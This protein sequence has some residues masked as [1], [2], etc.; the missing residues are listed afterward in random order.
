MSSRILIDAA[1][2]SQELRVAATNNGVVTH[3]DI[4]A[5]SRQQTKA[6]IYKGK[7]TRV[8][9]SLEAC[10]VDYGQE[11]HGFLPLKDISPQYFSKEVG[12]NERPSI[13]DV[14]KEGQELIIQVEKIERGNKGAALTTYITLA[15]SYLVLMPNSPKAGGVSRR[16]EGDER[17]ELLDILRQLKTPEQMG[18][19]IRTASIGKTLEDLQWDLDILIKLWGSINTV[20]NDNAA[21]LLIHQESNAMIRALRDYIRQETSEIVINNEDVYNEAR[22]YMGLI[23]P[24][25]ADKVTL[26][27]DDKPLF[28]H[29]QIERQIEAIFSHEVRLPSGGSLAIDQTEALIAIDINSSKATKGSDI[30]ETAFATN[31]EA[32]DEIARQ[33]RLRDIGGLIVIDFIDMM[34]NQNQRAVED[35]IRD[36]LKGDRAKVQI[37]RIS[38][39][40]LLEMSRQR[41]RA[42]MAESTR[43]ACPHCEGHGMVRSIPS[44]ALS[45]LRDIEEKAMPSDVSQIRVHLPLEVATYLLNE[46]REGLG[47]IEKRCTISLL[48]IPHDNMSLLEKEIEIIRARGRHTKTPSF[49]LAVEFKKASDT[50]VENFGISDTDSINHAPA[51]KSLDIPDKPT[52]QKKQ[53]TTKKT[54]LLSKII[55]A[56]FG[57][58]KKKTKASQQRRRPQQGRGRQ[59]NSR[60][61]NQGGNQQRRSSQS[62]NRRNTTRNTSS[63]TRKPQNRDASSSNT[64]SSNSRDS[65]RENSSRE[66]SSRENSSRDSGSRD[67]GSRSNNR[68]NNRNSNNRRNS[69]RTRSNDDRRGNEKNPSTAAS[70]NAP[71]GNKAADTQTKTQTPRQESKPQVVKQATVQASVVEKPKAPAPIAAAAP[72][73]QFKPRGGMPVK[74]QD[75][76]NKED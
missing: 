60:S 48:L 29:Y 69:N 49:K 56:L 70:S 52:A 36:A 38:R 50:D 42:T 54:G 16:I 4:E 39:F 43:I 18:I 8:E 27:T 28:T 75:Q 59:Q 22:K 47:Q 24:D 68:S 26:Y 14:I 33:L 1:Y 41:L 72:R 19:I 10:F 62:S 32:A 11:R 13:K 15:G 67:S 51:I 73:T 40:G 45:I 6:F 63:N 23:R 46:Q 74:K 65:S 71:L 12:E 37:G 34:Q 64:S 35:R 58:P 21:P 7:V 25:F 55:S 76:A 5:I 9:P 20:A 57:S 66:N 3:L 53:S 2:L 44:L 31:L 61:R 17:T 30:E